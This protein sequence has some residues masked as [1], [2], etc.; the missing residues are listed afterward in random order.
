M[1][2]R[3]IKL[4]TVNHYAGWWTILGIDP[5][6]FRLVWLMN[7]VCP[8][9]HPN[10][11]TVISLGA[12]IGAAYLLSQG[13]Y[14][15][16]GVLYEVSFLFDCL[17]GKMAR[18]QS[19]DKKFG[20]FFDSFVNSFVYCVALIG[21]GISQIENPWMLGGVFA[22]LLLHVLGLEMAFHQKIN[23]GAS[24]DRAPSR[25]ISVIGRLKEN[26][27]LMWPDRHLGVFL[28]M[29]LLGFPVIGVLANAVIDA[30]L[31]TLRFIR[32]ARS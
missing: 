10:F 14:L 18:L 19:R 22:A 5:I 16:G 25:E 20:Q 1:N 4:K 23:G 30:T 6:A 28:I 31:Q 13:E 17:D 27:P 24:S 12:G 29:P 9:I 32:I 2:L 21:L 7:R 26:Y 3:E 15:W 11:L 8:R